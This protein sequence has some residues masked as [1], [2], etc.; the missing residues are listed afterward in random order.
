MNTV[1]I[2]QET[3]KRDRQSGNWHRVHDFTPALEYGDLTFLLDG[4]FLPIQPQ[5]IIEELRRKLSNFTSE[6]Y[7]LLAGDPVALGLA[8][9]IA[10]E[11]TDG[12]FKLLKW[13]RDAGRYMTIQ[14]KYR[15]ENGNA[16]V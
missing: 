10:S 6:D 3:M 13:D 1:Y 14:V 5:P 4:R 9:M 16:R 12:N 15:K 8:T 7:L 11:K 2:V